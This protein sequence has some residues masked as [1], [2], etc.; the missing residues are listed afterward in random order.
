MASTVRGHVFVPQDTRAGGYPKYPGDGWVGEVYLNLPANAAI[1]TIQAEIYIEGKTPDFTF[2]TRW[3]DFPSGPESFVLDADLATVGD[4]FDDYIFE[5][6]DPAKLDEP[7]S[8]MLVRFTGLLKV[9]MEDEVRTLT[10]AFLPTWIE[11]GSFG[12]DGYNLRVGG[13]LSYERFDT[14][15]TEPWYN[16]GPAVQIQGLFPIMVTY[17]NRYDPDD[18]SN[19]PFAGFE[20]YSWHGGGAAWPAGQ[21]M[22]HAVRG[23]GTLAPPGIIY[24]PGDE[25][26]VPEGDFDADADVDDKDF[27]WFQNCFFPPNGFIILPDGCDTFDFAPDNDVDW[28]DLS[29]FLKL[30]EGPS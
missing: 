3:I 14:N 11:F 21:N 6:S 10:T 17:L 27:Q 30:L 26:L 9:R 4:F 2:R 18:T 25:L 19:A 20:L 8:S 23:F 15:E 29:T 1:N 5:V 22:L 24:Q 7:M 12:Y 16:W 13:I 28:D